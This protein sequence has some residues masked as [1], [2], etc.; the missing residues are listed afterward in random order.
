MTDI[1]QL[2]RQAREAQGLSLADVEEQTRIR[3]RYL[4]ALEADDW[5]ELPNEVVA[6]G[7]LRTYAA[8]LGIDEPEVQQTIRTTTSTSSATTA[9]VIEPQ[10]SISSEYRPIDLSLYE[11]TVGRS[12]R[13]RRWFTFF[14]VVIVVALL[15]VLFV[16]YGLPWLQTTLRPPVAAPPPAT[17]PPEGA[18]PATLIIAVERETPST[19]EAIPTFTPTSTPTPSPTNTPTLTPTPTAT[20][21]TQLELRVQISQRAWVRLIVDGEIEL[22]NFLDSGFDQTF[23]AQESL[24]LLAG[25]AAGVQLTLNG[26]SLPP[27]GEVG[28]VVHWIWRIGEGEVIVMT[29]TP[30]PTPEFSP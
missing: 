14:I 17:I 5:D 2:L 6:R 1:G 15:V 25:N 19:S 23:V 26:D 21:V 9:P 30:T 28:E 8:F 11:T 22:Q 4:A 13:L 24:E 12:R 10:A 20:P 3:Q 29:P 7:F 16:Q 18:P 27:L